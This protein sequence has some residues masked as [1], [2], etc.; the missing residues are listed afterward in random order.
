MKISRFVLILLVGLSLIMAV[1][2][3]HFGEKTDA[4][5]MLGLGIVNMQTL[6]MS[7]R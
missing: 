5:W 7:T 6:A 3:W 2:N 4:F 1:F